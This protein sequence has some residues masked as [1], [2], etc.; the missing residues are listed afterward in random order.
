[1]G[2]EDAVTADR[3]EVGLGDLTQVAAARAPLEQRQRQQRR[4]SLVHV[5]N[6][7]RTAPECVHHRDAAQTQQSFLKQTIA[8]VP[9]VQVIGQGLVETEFSGSDVS[10]M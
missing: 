4:V 2:G 3:F 9:T 6:E 8:V 10:S 1:M 7:I 5:I